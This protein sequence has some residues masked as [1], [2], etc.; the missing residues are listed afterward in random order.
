MTDFALKG[1]I[2]EGKDVDQEE[3]YLKA[4]REANQKLVELTSSEVSKATLKLITK[5]IEGDN[6]FQSSAA[7]SLN[8]LACL[9]SSNDATHYK[10]II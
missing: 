8:H 2:L 10:S 3:A 9:C 6:A 5:R 4:I 1:V 7:G